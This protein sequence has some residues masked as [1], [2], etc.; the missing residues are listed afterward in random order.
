MPAA[1]RALAG[2]APSFSAESCDAL[3]PSNEPLLS[4]SSRA[5]MQASALSIESCANVARGRSELR[6]H[7]GGWRAGAHGVGPADGAG[8]PLLAVRHDLLAEP[9]RTQRCGQSAAEQQQSGA[10]GSRRWP[11]PREPEVATC[12]PSIVGLR[13]VNL[14]P[15][16][17]LIRPLE[18]AQPVAAG[19]A[20]V[21]ALHRLDGRF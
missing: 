14:T 20:P 9:A 7:S 1:G 18:L 13:L 6:E 2:S 5:P 19:R 4:T 8:R 11:S 21:D 15:A 3:I 17:L 10:T 12:L 16:V